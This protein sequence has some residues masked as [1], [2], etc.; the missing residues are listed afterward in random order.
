[1]D[2]YAKNIEE[3]FAYVVSN[4]S[5][6]TSYP[7]HLEGIL[8]KEREIQEFKKAEEQFRAYLSKIS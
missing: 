8:D 6:D 1:L 3:L 4:F 2:Y 7:E 5:K